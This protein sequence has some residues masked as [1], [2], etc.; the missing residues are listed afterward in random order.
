M[1]L[2]E[3]IRIAIDN[4]KALRRLAGLNVVPTGRT[5][6][7]TAVQNTQVDAAQARF[8]PTVTFFNRFTQRETDATFAP[9]LGPPLTF[10][11]AVAD[12]VG[13]LL[14]VQQTNVSGGTLQAIAADV[15]TGFSG[16]RLLDSL[17]WPSVG[18]GYTQPFLQGAGRPVNMAPIVIAQIRTEYSFYQA[19]GDTQE[20]VRSVI[21]AY[22][23]LVYAR[24]VCWA[25][26]QQ[27]VQGQEA[28][29]RA[30]AQRQV[31][32]G[33][34]ADVAQSR[35]AAANFRAELIS[36]EGTMLQREGAL[37]NLLGIPAYDPATIVPTTS[38]S[39]ERLS[40]SWNEL[41]D[42]AGQY[43]PDLIEL[44]LVLEADQQQEIIAKS[45]AMPQLN[46]HAGFVWNGLEGST[47]T[48]GD[49]R[50]DSA[51]WNVGVSFSVPLGLRQ[52]RANLRQKQL[53]LAA[54][55]ANLE[56]GM[57]SAEH[58][59]ANTYR[60]LVQYYEQYLAFK[61]TASAARANL[62]QQMADFRF[63]KGLYLNVLQAITQ[64]G[65]AVRSE[66]QALSLYNTELANLES[67]TGTI[68]KTHGIY[69]YEDCFCSRGPGGRLGKERPY[70]L[71]VAPKSGDKPIPSV[72]SPPT[73]TDY[74]PPQGTAPLDNSHLLP[75]ET[76]PTPEGQPAP[77]PGANPQPSPTRGRPPQLQYPVPVPPPPSTVSAAP[78]LYGPVPMIS[79]APLQP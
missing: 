7:D 15:S 46:A 8:D 50:I 40:A 51:G 61:E 69:F 75:N 1:S 42:L 2:D 56:E 12:R 32:L 54:D 34:A 59:L 37:R 38:P 14:T 67:R 24:V 74:A 16:P 23:N 17:G 30:E 36:A 47:I 26:R 72:G 5:I 27:V 11:G 31:G 18:I 25:R 79:V 71:D 78:P 60:S 76:L 68:L 4:A 19:Q 63:R 22:W 77:S 62:D 65:D 73:S 9:A 70:P 3:A 43:R 39:N 44:K 52:G 20:L 33:S 55:R 53:L 58:D 64:W 35:A 48:G 49:F 41:L 21:E 29:E 28:Y 45:Q 10:P 66:A 13:N 6:Y 57:H